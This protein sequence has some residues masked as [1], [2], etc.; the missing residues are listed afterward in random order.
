MSIEIITN[1]VAPTDPKNDQNQKYSASRA[2]TTHFGWCSAC[3][4]KLRISIPLTSAAVAPRGVQTGAVQVQKPPAEWRSSRR[5]ACRRVAFHHVA[6]FSFRWLTL[7]DWC[8]NMHNIES[9]PRGSFRRGRHETGHRRRRGSVVH[10]QN[11]NMVEE[12]KKYFF[13]CRGLAFEWRGGRA[14]MRFIYLLFLFI[15]EAHKQPMSGVTIAGLLCCWFA[16][17]GCGPYMDLAVGN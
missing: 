4:V 15:C 11:I 6:A 8:R 10:L 2:T 5:P 17:R 16:L 14:I 7:T 13:F 3:R 1:S 9:N 12:G